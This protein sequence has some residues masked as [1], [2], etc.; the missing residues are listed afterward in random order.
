[1]KILVYL[2]FLLFILYCCYCL[3]NI[4]ED[5]DFNSINFLSRP[6]KEKQ[7]QKPVIIN[8]PKQLIKMYKPT[9]RPADLKNEHKVNVSNLQ[10]VG[11]KLF[12][13][14]QCRLLSECTDDYQFTGAVFDGVKCQNQV[15]TKNATAIATIKNGYISHI[16]IIDK[17]NEYISSPLIS[18][19][20]GNGENAKAKCIIDEKN[21]CLKKIDIISRGRNYT[22]TPTIVIEKPNNNSK[23][24]LCCK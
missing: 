15:E 20:G 4:Q 12:N 3:F 8:K 9:L 22:S 23:C 5:F 17:G 21:K 14:L 10:P 16:H 2:T 1:M 7:I 11:N 6:K 13:N 18:I 24:K 19:I